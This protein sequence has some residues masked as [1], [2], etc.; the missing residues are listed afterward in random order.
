[1]GLRP[2]GTGTQAIS[3][4]DA[5]QRALELVRTNLTEVI[6]PGV[7]LVEADPERAD[8]LLTEAYEQLAVASR[9]G[10]RAATIDPLREQTIEGLDRLYGVVPVSSRDL[11]TFK[12]KE[13]KPPIDLKAVVRGPD[14]APFVLDASTK[15]V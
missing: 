15:T 14:G 10:I 5:G 9:N 2:G 6:G 3:S 7:D 1:M 11:F 12:P 8:E 13:D 4:I